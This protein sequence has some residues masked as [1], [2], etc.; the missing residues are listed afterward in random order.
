MMEYEKI[1]LDL[2]IRVKTLEEKV[3][4]LS[5]EKNEFSKSNRELLKSESTLWE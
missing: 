2:L 5:N 3:E 4:Q 1:I